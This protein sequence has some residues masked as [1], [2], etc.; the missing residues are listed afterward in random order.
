MNKQKKTSRC[1][2]MRNAI[3]RSSQFARR[4]TVVTQWNISMPEGQLYS[5]GILRSRVHTPKCHKYLLSG[6]RIWLFSE[7]AQ[8]PIPLST[9]PR[10]L[11]RSSH[12]NCIARSRFC[13]FSSPCGGNHHHHFVCRHFSSTSRYLQLS[14]LI[15]PF[16]RDEE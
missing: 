3:L 16:S 11:Q 2:R 9:L 14:F 7:R 10:P 6:E 4:N 12:E 15:P 1:A 13:F 5:A 8:T